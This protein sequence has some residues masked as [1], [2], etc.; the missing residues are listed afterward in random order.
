MLTFHQNDLIDLKDALAHCYLTNQSDLGIRTVLLAQVVGSVGRSHD[1]DRSFMPGQERIKDRWFNVNRAYY[2]D[3]PLPPI[4]LEQVGDNYFVVDGH[5][6][7]SV[8]RIHGLQYIEAHVIQ[9]RAQCDEHPQM[10]GARVREKLRRAK[11][12]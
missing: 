10:S 3:I 12:S 5:H 2:L 4:E 8:A 9:H 7:V 6:R 1:F 11:Q